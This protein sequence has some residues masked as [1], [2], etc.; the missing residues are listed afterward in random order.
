MTHNRKIAVVTL[1]VI[2]A[3]VFAVACIEYYSLTRYTCL[4]CRATLTKERIMMIPFERITHDDSAI[5][6]QNRA[7]SHQHQWRWHG[8]E[9]TWST[10]AFTRACG[11]QHPICTFIPSLQAQYAGMVSPA[12]YADTLKKID[13]A[14]REAA[15]QLIS[16]AEERVM[17][18][19]P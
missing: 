1:C 9:Q 15:N 2:L 12:E 14:D 3:T 18:T 6:L 19:W 5:S 4:H 13:S 10:M 8:S 7:P 11:R 16:Q 17:D